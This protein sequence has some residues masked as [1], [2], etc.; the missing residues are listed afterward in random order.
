MNKKIAF[1]HAVTG[2]FDDVMRE[3]P[4]H[5]PPEL[6]APEGYKVMIGH[7]DASS[8]RVDISTGEVV[9]YQPPPPAPEQLALDAKQRILELEA[10]QSRAQREAALYGDRS[11]LM[12]IEQ[13]ILEQRQI[14]HENSI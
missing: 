12:Q 13:Q 5:I 10:S 1:Y 3:I 11:R 7:Y 2:L 6:C 9:E 8:Q 14:I 4:D